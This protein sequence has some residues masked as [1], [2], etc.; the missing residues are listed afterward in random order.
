MNACEDFF[1]TVTAGL[2]ISAALEMLSFDT[3]DNMPSD[4]SM[5]GAEK[6]CT[7]TA[8]ERLLCLWKQIYDKFVAFKYNDS[9]ASTSRSDLVV[10]YSVQLLRMGCFYMEFADAIR[11]ED[12]RRV[13]R[14]WKYMAV[15][16]SNSGN[17]NYACEAANLLIQYYYVLSPRQ[18]SQLLLSKFVN[19]HGRPGRNIPVDLH[20]EH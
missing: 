8:D 18:A 9:T 7:L 12:G 20:M 4:I 14:C 11:E 13:L 5:P 15:M 6:L 10:K 17:R 19:T 1:E 2:I 16:F 3:V